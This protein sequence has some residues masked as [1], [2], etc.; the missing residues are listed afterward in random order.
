MMMMMMDNGLRRIMI[1]M[2]IKERKKRKN[3]AVGEGWA[4]SFT[5]TFK[6]ALR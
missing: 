4:S 5:N 1:R 6:V 2:M 3:L